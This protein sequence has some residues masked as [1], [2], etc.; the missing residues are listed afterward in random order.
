[1]ERL[2]D[3]LESFTGGKVAIV[4]SALPFKCPAAPYEA[5][6][7]LD[8]YFQKKGV[9]GKTDID[10]FTPEALPFPAAGP[11]IG[12]K[13]AGMLKERKIGFTPK[14]SSSR[15]ISR[16]KSFQFEHGRAARFDLLIFV[17]PHQGAERY[18][19]FSSG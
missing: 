9:R 2:R 1:M 6:F 7:L 16:K 15:L 14:S 8:E 4:I 18:Q 19:K 12:K 5:A 3:G 13:V 10:I 11:D 17:P